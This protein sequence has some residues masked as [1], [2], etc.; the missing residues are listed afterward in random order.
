MRGTRR[1]VFS[2]VLERSGNRGGVRW[3]AVWGKAPVL[4]ERS[5]T[6][7]RLRL[8]LPGFTGQPRRTRP[9]LTAWASQYS[10]S[11]C[12]DVKA[13]C[14]PTLRIFRTFLQLAVFKALSPQPA[15]LP[16]TE[17]TCL[18]RR[19]Q[20]SALSTSR[21]ETAKTSFFPMSCSDC[22]LAT[23]PPR[24]APNSTVGPEPILRTE[25]CA[26]TPRILSMR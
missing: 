6:I 12:L 10:R 26:R 1:K 16:L 20:K 15:R 21:S 9:C 3:G 25:S 18:F 4:A 5:E 24:V 14:V 17:S 11:F 22:K 8:S 19:H 2:A 13:R 23:L 7:G